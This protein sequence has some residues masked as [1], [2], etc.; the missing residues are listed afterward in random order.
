MNSATC[1]KRNANNYCMCEYFKEDFFYYFLIDTFIFCIK[2]F[3]GNSVSV[4]SD[5]DEIVKYI[6][7]FLDCAL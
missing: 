4:C 2:Y 5:I 7:D 1:D 6:N 3:I